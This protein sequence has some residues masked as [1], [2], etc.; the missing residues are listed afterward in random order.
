MIQRFVEAVAEQR[1]LAV[2]LELRTQQVVALE[3]IGRGQR[4]HAQAVHGTLGSAA[5]RQLHAADRGFDGRGQA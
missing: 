1:Q 3:D 2:Q 5:R 4:G